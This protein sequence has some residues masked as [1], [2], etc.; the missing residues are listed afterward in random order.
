MLVPRERAQRDRRPAGRAGSVFGGSGRGVAPCGSA[1]ADHRARRRVA[2]ASVPAA[3]AGREAWRARERADP[4]ARAISRCCSAH[5]R[6]SPTGAGR[7][8]RWLTGSCSPTSARST[9]GTSRRWPRPRGLARRCSAWCGSCVGAGYDLADLGPLLDGATDA[10]EKAGSLAEILAVVRAA[11]R[12]LLRPRR[13]AGRP[14]IRRGSTGSALL[15]WGMLD[16][17]PALERLIA[18]IAERMPVDVYLPDASA[19]AADAPLRALRQ[20]LIARR[21][22][23]A[24][25]RR[26]GRSRHRRSTRVRAAAVHAAVEAG[27][28]RRTGRVRLVSAPDPAR[29]VRA[30]ARA[31]LRVGARGRAVLGHGG[32]LS[33]RRGV[34]AAGRGGVRRGR[35]PASTCTR[36]RRWPSVRSA[37]RRSALLD[38]VST[39]SCRGSR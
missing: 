26:V 39:A 1:G 9:R 14:P 25:R 34:S 30:A 21:S 13:R 24:S 2:A 7:C 5:R 19:A 37:A 29:E 8:R 6:S 32:R 18:G 12:R 3:L 16:M 10:P 33:A 31:C 20:R 23:R 36:A 27:D 22:R 38:A 28:R 35:D 17:P 11:A 4:D 15:V